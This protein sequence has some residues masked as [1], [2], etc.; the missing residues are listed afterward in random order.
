MRQS[1][2][3]AAAA[4]HALDHQRDRLIEDHA[5]ARRLAEGV[6]EL[7][8]LAIAMPVAT[9][10]VFIDVSPEIGSAQAVSDLL[11]DRGV[12]MLPTAPQRLR[13]VC[14]LEVSGPMI[15]AALLAL[16]EVCR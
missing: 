4:L 16:R 10:M 2:I 7:P 8:G 12:W 11:K 5:H 1:G 3:L 15:D 13:A 6:A 14:H 9:N